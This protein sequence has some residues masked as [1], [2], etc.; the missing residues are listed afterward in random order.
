MS[1]T[2]QDLM[3]KKIKWVI[4][5]TSGIL[6]FFSACD[7]SK[8]TPVSKANTPVL[9][10]PAT[11]SLHPQL[12]VFHIS[13]V[14]SQLNIMLTT[15]E[16]LVN[17]ANPDRVSMANIKI[18]YQL[19]DCT[20]IENNKIV[21][22]S[23]TYV[24]F[25]EIKPQQTII[26]FPILFPAN[27][28]RRYMMSIQTTDVLRHNTI[29]QFLTVDKTDIYSAQNF[30]LFVPNG[31]PIL[32]KT[33]H[34]NSI[35]RILYQR[36]LVDSLYI[37]Y[38]S[39][40]QPIATSPVSVGPVPELN[41]KADSVWVQAYTPNT[42][43]MMPYEGLYFIQT[44]T[45]QQDGLLLANFGAN[46]PRENRTSKLV[47]PIQYLVTAAEYRK[48]SEESNSKK[49]MDNFWLSTTGSTDKSRMLIRVFYTR[50][51]YANQFFT[52]Y[53]EGWKTDRGMI[54]MIYGLP[55]RVLKGSD[56]E[57]WE[58]TLKQNANPLTFVF[59]K[60]TSPYS[61]NHFVLQRGS[62]QTTYWQ[63][64]ISSWRK[65]SIFSVKDL[66]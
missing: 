55:D 49:M 34:A 31:P 18:H 36:K 52:D 28:G 40:S 38:T 8:K 3:K 19:F 65:G 61:D 41:L 58:Y 43:F 13:D 46:F 37:K 29:K 47:E 10:N 50:M 51:T 57:T 7:S 59:T 23:A 42:S 27:N 1:D 11:S 6:L 32:E 12:G 14:E 20:E 24:N 44:D 5:L 15:N 64:A 63:Q 54:Y 45:T 16:L 22:D 66:E 60:K 53:E 4:C 9:Y 35:F 39:I 48:L 21:A 26:V 62:P 17:Q 2:K 25:V 33:I 30:K 56:A